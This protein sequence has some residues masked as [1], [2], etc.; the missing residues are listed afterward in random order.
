MPP[1]LL[2]PSSCTALHCCLQPLAYLAQRPASSL[3]PPTYT[4]HPPARPQTYE[5]LCQA[6][7][8][9]QVQ[10]VQEE[11]QLREQDFGNFQDMEGK[12]REKAERLRFGRFFYRFPN[13]ESGADVYD[14]WVGGQADGRMGGL[15]IGCVL[16]QGAWEGGLCLLMNPHVTRPHF[17]PVAALPTPLCLPTPCPSHPHP[18]HPHPLHPPLHPHHIMLLLLQDDAV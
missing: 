7:R 17:T 13:G 9:D 6:F 18:L 1:L 4:P 14:R 12:K 16:E 15:A 3:P 10:G 2:H 8:P 5:G 11:V